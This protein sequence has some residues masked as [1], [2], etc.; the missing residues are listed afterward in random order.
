MQSLVRLL[1]LASSDE[2]CSDTLDILC[3][4]PHR[5]FRKTEWKWTFSLLHFCSV[6]KCIFIN[7]FC[8][9]DLAPFLLIRLILPAYDLRGKSGAPSGRGDMWNQVDLLCGMSLRASISFGAIVWIWAIIIGTKIWK[10]LNI[11]SSWMIAIQLVYMNIVLLL[12][13]WFCPPRSS[14]NVLLPVLLEEPKKRDCCCRL[15]FSVRWLGACDQLGLVG[16]YCNTIVD[17]LVSIVKDVLWDFSPWSKTSNF[18]CTSSGTFRAYGRTC[19]E[20]GWA[21]T[22]SHLF[23]KL[24]TLGKVH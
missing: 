6:R 15:T 23:A 5:G 11:G 18:D 4:L 7:R 21:G 2:Y 1:N 13:G 19:S 24:G 16:I 14:T 10:L 22:C 9:G 8:Q 20:S 3:P 17:V 12:Q